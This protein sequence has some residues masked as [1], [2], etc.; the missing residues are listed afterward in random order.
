MAKKLSKEVEKLLTYKRVF[1]DERGKR[2]ERDFVPIIQN[3]GEQ[4]ILYLYEVISQK[5]GRTFTIDLIKNIPEEKFI[6]FRGTFILP[7][8]TGKGTF[9]CDPESYEIVFDNLARLLTKAEEEKMAAL[10]PAEKPD[11]PQTRH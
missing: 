5:Y 11:A 8:Y 2:V 7:T 6:Y 9:Y 1:I 3:I 4:E 10:L